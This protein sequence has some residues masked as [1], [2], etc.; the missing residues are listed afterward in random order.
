MFV[1][2]YNK[3]VL[4]YLLDS[5]L[6]TSLIFGDTSSVVD[7]RIIRRFG[8]YHQTPSPKGGP[9]RVDQ[10]PGCVSVI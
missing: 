6:L 10:T 7:L 2:F 8:H 9:A 4:D 5:S 1:F 3:V